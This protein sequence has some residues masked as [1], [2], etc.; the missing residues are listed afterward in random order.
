MGTLPLGSMSGDLRD[1]PHFGSDKLLKMD[2][3]QINKRLIPIKTHY[4]LFNGALAGVIPFIAVYAKQLEI[5]ADVMGIIFA[6]VSSATV[7]S[8]PLLG[9]LVD[10][11]QKLKLVL[12][13]LVMIGIISDLGM[14]FIPQPFPTPTNSSN[15]SLF[16]HGNNSYLIQ[17]QTE[18]CIREFPFCGKDCVSSCYS[19]EL[20]S[21]ACSKTKNSD[22]FPMNLSLECIEQFLQ[23]CENDS[24]EWCRKSLEDFDESGTNTTENP[25]VQLCMMSIFTAIIYMCMGSTASLS[26][27]ACFSMLEDKPHLYGKQR[28]WGTIGWGSFALLAGYLN[29]VVTD[30]SSA[31]NYSAGFYMGIVLFVMDMLMITQFKVENAK[32]SKNIFRDVGSLIVKPRILLFLL[33]V[34][35]VG[36]FRGMSSYYVFWYLR[37][38]NASQFLLGCT[39]AVL[40]FL[41]ELPFFFFS[42]WIIKKIGHMNTFVMSFTSYGIKYLSYSFIQNPWWSL[43]IEILQG[44]CY[45]SLYAALTSYAKIIAPEG[46]EATVQGIASGTLEGLGVAAGCLIGGYGFQNLGGRKTFFWTGMVCFI[47]A[48]LTCINNAVQ[49]FQKAKFKRS[50]ESSKP[51]NS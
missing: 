4:L 39:S 29:Q 36:I 30:T 19:C 23:N 41:G 11:F 32:T 21:I 51:L 33:Q 44:P 18:S 48:L 24:A 1:L 2:K 40:C 3:I 14:N 15:S 47:L 5:S 31:Y 50:S 25:L 37:T 9:I 22:Q 13:C 12:L 10:H 43:L 42:G 35:F 45:G 20:D 26:D 17:F 8:R 38:L 49:A 28:M 34:L 46:T 16:C 27:A 6:V 7:V